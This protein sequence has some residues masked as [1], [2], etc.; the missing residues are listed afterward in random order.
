MQPEEGI[1]NLKFPV[2][3]G[4]CPPGSLQ[5]A[6]EQAAGAGRVGG[7]VLPGPTHGCLFVTFTP[8]TSSL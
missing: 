2:T 4:R 6:S 7:E 1:E 8:M 5:G 3:D